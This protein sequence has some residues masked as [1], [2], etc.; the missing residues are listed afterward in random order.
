MDFHIKK[1]AGTGEYDHCGLSYLSF[2]VF[3]HDRAFAV[4]PPHQALQ[5]LQ[6]HLQQPDWQ[7]D[8]P[9][10]HPGHKGLAYR[11]V[12]GHFWIRSIYGCNLS[13]D[14]HIG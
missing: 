6:H 10:G 13:D 4:H 9:A 12:G 1:R 5:T 8:K 14:D 2:L 7:P 11:R 3:I